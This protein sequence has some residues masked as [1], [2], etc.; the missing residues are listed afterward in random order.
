MIAT[1]YITL[2]EIRERAH[3]LWERAGRPEGRAEDHWHAAE[4]QLRSERDAQHPEEDRT[5]GA[6]PPEIH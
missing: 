1:D 4:R 5:L 3:A 2:D 6:Q